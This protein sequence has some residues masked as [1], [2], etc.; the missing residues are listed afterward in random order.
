M[1]QAAY[2]YIGEGFGA[3][4]LKPNKHPL[5]PEG[6]QYLYQLI[7]EDDIDSLFMRADKIGIACGE[8]SGGFYCID[9]DAHNGENIRQVFNDFMRNEVVK[10]II[11]THKLPVFKTPSGGY[12][13]Y[14]RHENKKYGGH[15]ISKWDTGKTM[16]EVRGHGQYVC[17]FPSLGYKKL[18]GVD[19][20]EVSEITTE[21][22]DALFTIAESFN[23]HIAPPEEHKGT[24]VWPEKFDTSKLTGRY[25]ENEAEHAKDLL[26]EAGWIMTR[27]RRHDNVELWLRPGKEAKENGTP[28]HSATFG[29]LHN[30]FY[31][32]TESD[33]IFKSWRGYSPF[34]ILLK[35]KFNGEFKDAIKWLEER[36][37]PKFEPPPTPEH[38][39]LQDNEDIPAFPIDVFPEDLRAFIEQLSHT[40][41]YSKDFLS[42]SAMFTISICNGNT[43]KLKVKNGW[44]APTIFWFAVVGEPGTM[45]SHP[46]STMISPIH[47]IDRSSKVVYDEEM[48]EWT[49]IDKD[50]RPR[51]PRFRQ[52]LISDYTLEALHDVHDFNKRGIGLYK[53][54]LV[55]FLNDMNKY[56]KGSDEQFW[57]ESFNNKSYVV[58]R[59]T[60]EPIFI[61]D[62]NINIL[63]TIQPNVL[64]HIVKEFNGNG[65]IDRFLYSR[66]ERDI[67]PMSRKD[68]NERWIKWWD[69][70]VRNANQ[71][72]QY[73]DNVSTKVI[74]LDDDAMELFYQIDTDLI[75]LQLSDGITSNM[76]GYLN[77]MKTY[78]PRFALLMAL[79]DL[80]SSGMIT[81]VNV[82]HMQ[83]A[84]RIITYFIES[85][86]VIFNESEAAMEIS[87][88]NQ[89]LFGKTKKER[90]V[91]LWQ[92]GFKQPEICKE[93]NSP[94]QFVNRIIKEASEK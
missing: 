77:K 80:L 61:E 81:N 71:Y 65:L 68:I 63:G 16:I 5:L 58:N 59:V 23:Q 31:V 75:N 20:V 43:I 14:Y 37:A 51:K 8:V 2:T 56:R 92:K 86:K 11:D 21:E 13:I 66:A 60:K 39:E 84:Q 52:I 94:K 4:P 28:A 41:N 53:D 93:L 90:I 22:R 91:I 76:K 3:I 46:I 48:K 19:I 78:I 38:T 15:Y 44:V 9:F 25:S 10:N 26:R 72:F 79:F 73:I 64:N 6:H 54:E 42:L 70:L 1:I 32:Y 57:L 27:I 24:G 69:E 36:Y 62:I 40:L 18:A 55:G 89:S 87:A 12:H 17:C 83:K 82:S 74:T 29:K 49:A 85:A 50:R 33:S 35:L 34:D 7:K 67:L 30:M 88:V 45:K 47:G